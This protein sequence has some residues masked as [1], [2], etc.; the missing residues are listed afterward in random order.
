VGLTGPT[1]PPWL[2]LQSVVPRMEPPASA[3]WGQVSVIRGG[4][5]G[6]IAEGLRPAAD[7]FHMYHKP[8]FAALNMDSELSACNFHFT[9]T[10]SEGPFINFQVQPG[11]ELNPQAVAT[12]N[13]ANVGDNS[14]S[15]TP[16]ANTG[17][18]GT[19]P[20]GIG[21]PVGVTGVHANVGAL[22]S[23]TSAS[24]DSATLGI[25]LLGIFIPLQL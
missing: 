13:V 20:I 1:R 19:D 22:G 15:V 2:V 21:V 23:S 18:P 3:A 7:G 12:N 8:A 16:L 5:R 4:R 25:S 9:N 14:A 11:G 24:V 10:G 17:I 6:P